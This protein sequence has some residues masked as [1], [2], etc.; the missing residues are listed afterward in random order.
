MA[1]QLPVRIER[2]PGCVEVHIRDASN[3]VIAPDLIAIDAQEIVEALNAKAAPRRR[4]KRRPLADELRDSDILAQT[5]GRTDIVYGHHSELPQG[6]D[7]VA[8]LGTKRR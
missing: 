4:S 5:A 1:I 2:D 7:H 3:R 6:G 8:R